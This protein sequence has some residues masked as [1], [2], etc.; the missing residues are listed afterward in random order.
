MRASRPD[1]GVRLRVRPWVGGRAPRGAATPAAA[2]RR[3]EIPPAGYTRVYSPWRRCAIC[4]NVNCNAKPL[5]IEPNRDVHVIETREKPDFKAVRPRRPAEVLSP[6]SPFPPSW[7][8]EAEQRQE[9]AGS[10]PDPGSGRVWYYRDPE[11]STRGPFTKEVRG[12]PFTSVCHRPR[13]TIDSVRN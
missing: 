5:T 6:L 7:R 8:R 11:G 10:L 4:T 12:P 3:F 9:A 13:T 1:T 2:R